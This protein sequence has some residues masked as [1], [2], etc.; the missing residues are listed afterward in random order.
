MV[1]LVRKIIKNGAKSLISQK[2][3]IVAYK[4][5]FGRERETTKRQGGKSL[6]IVIKVLCAKSAKK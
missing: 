3:K 2:P 5:D 4:I 6:T 1:S